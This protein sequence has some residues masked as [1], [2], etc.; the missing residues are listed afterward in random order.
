MFNS[1][2]DVVVFVKQCLRT[3]RIWPPP[4]AELLSSKGEMVRSIN[5]SLAK[6][7]DEQVQAITV[8]CMYL[9]VGE[10]AR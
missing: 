4:G 3:A 5:D 10:V 9:E 6:M 7:N 2:N 1:V 8:L